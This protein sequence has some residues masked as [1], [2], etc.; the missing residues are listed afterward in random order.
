[1]KVVISS[2][3]A[4]YIV[5]WICHEYGRKSGDLAPLIHNNYFKV[6]RLNYVINQYVFRDC[7]SNTTPPYNQSGD[8]FRF[9][10]SHRHALSVQAQWKL[11]LQQ[12]CRLIDCIVVCVTVR[13]RNVCYE[14]VGQLRAAVAL[15]LG[16]GPCHS[17]GRL[18][19][20]LC[21]FGT[22][23]EENILWPCRES[24]HDSSYSVLIFMC[25]ASTVPLGVQLL[26]RSWM[27]HAYE[28]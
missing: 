16:W 18:D 15:S 7:R 28:Q 26:G 8:T 12:T 9:I 6:I 20:T 23:D 22:C 19:G 10:Q 11:W 3:S 21:L 14:V 2:D 27:V 24:N 13:S 4:P 1:M 25:K 5:D 17:L